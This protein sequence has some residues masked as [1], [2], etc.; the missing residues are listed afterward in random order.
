[1][2]QSLTLVFIILIIII[3]FECYF[4]SNEAPQIRITDGPIRGDITEY[5]GVNILSY[6]GIPYAKSPVGA[7]RFTPPMKPDTWT[8]P[9]Y[10]KRYGPSCIQNT[11]SVPFY[12]L[13][14]YYKRHPQDENCLFINIFLPEKSFTENESLPVMVF[15][16]GG[17]FIQGAGNFDSLSPNPLVAI[18]NIVIVSFNYRLGPFGF[19][20]AGSDVPDIKSNLGFQDQVLALQWV[21]E[22]I[23]SFRGDPSRVTIFGYSSGSESVSL[24]IMAR[25]S[26]KFFQN[27]IMQSGI[28]WSGNKKREDL[29]KISRKV[30]QHF[31]C[32]DSVNVL[33]CLQ[34]VETHKLSNETFELI[35]KNPALNPFHP[36]I[37]DSFLP[38]TTSQAL[39]TRNFNTDKNLLAG[40]EKNDIAF[41]LSGPSFPWLLNLTYNGAVEQ[42]EFLVG[43]GPSAN[44]FIHRYIHPHREG[45]ASQIMLGFLD[46]ADDLIFHCPTHVLSSLIANT[47]RTENVS[48]FNYLHTQKLMKPENSACPKD[49]PELG[50]CHTDELHY[51]FGSPLL[52]PNEFD[53]IDAELSLRMMTIWTQFARTGKVPPQGPVNWPPLGS[54]IEENFVMDLNGKKIGALH[55]EKLEYCTMNWHHFLRYHDPDELDGYRHQKITY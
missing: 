30:I 14:A 29:I 41:L 23:A 40:T 9:I 48:V 22:N 21:H 35:G 18:H 7:L 55:H 5:H 26:E 39:K 50:P 43:K 36:V 12:S 4:T 37:G 28:S 46:F 27:A 34:S 44:F 2:N 38:F 17:Y 24:H 32:S 15:I 47:S 33:S 31:N 3:R 16:H 52:Y 45:T 10:G 49:F 53:Q 13:K 42:V 54:K 20:C 1:M 25:V 51:V 6:K 11:R 19:L 8:V